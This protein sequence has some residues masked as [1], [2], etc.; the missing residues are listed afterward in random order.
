M[1]GG[2]SQY[3]P[4]VSVIISTFNRKEVLKRAIKSVLDQSMPDF[5]C[6]VVDDCSPQEIEKLV[7]SFGDP[8]LKYLRTEKN[9]GHDAL[10]KNIGIM[11]ARGKY[12]A[13]LD[14]DD[15]YKKDALRILTRYAEETGVDVTYGD[16]LIDGKPGWSIDFSASRLAQHNYISMCSALV[17]RTAVL[18][19]GGFDEDV[20]KFKDWNLWL[21]IHKNG[22]TF[23]HVPIIVFYIHQMEKSISAD[24]PAD[25]DEAG[26][27]KPTYFNPADCLIYPEKTILGKRPPL[28]VAVYTL[29]M[30]R[31]DYTKQMYKSIDTLAGYPFDWFVIDQGS[32]DGTGDWI[33][34]L[35]RDREFSDAGTSSTWRMK[36]RYRIYEKNVGLAK[37]WNNI[38]EFIKTE[39]KDEPYDLIIKVDN[40]AEMLTEGWL[41]A[42]IEIYKRNRKVCLSPA[43]E[44]LETLPGG[45][46]RQRASGESPYVMIA[47][48]VLG[49]VPHLGGIVYSTPIEIWKEWKFDEAYEGNKDVLLSQYARKEGYGLFYMEEFRVWHIDGTHGQKAKY[50]EYFSDIK[51]EDIKNVELEDA[52]DPA[53]Q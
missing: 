9:S 3:A 10:P 49:V 33:K 41:A 23:M 53:G 50:P 26:R 25:K 46:L 32:T 42:M 16:Y 47:D 36:L 29:A 7:L 51:V 15:E 37:G 31:L 11:A 4:K 12:L 6:I 22:G 20:P 39:S 52:K 13:F 19:V 14:D 21:R 17:S 45:V 24:I 27:Y 34:S 8:R 38:V 35:T 43:V 18:A 28:R 40:D 44:G 2:L 48:K 30:N 5:E 1:A